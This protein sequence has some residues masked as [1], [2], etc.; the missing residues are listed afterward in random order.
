M[1]S[2]TII[3][4]HQGLNLVP[5][6]GYLWLLDKT[7]S[8]RL[9]TK[10]LSAYFTLSADL[11][12]HPQ[13]TNQCLSTYLHSVLGLPPLSSRVGFGHWPP[14]L[15]KGWAVTLQHELH[16]REH[17]CITPKRAQVVLIGMMPTRRM[18]HGVNSQPSPNPRQVLRLLTGLPAKLDRAANGLICPAVVVSILEMC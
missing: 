11:C 13:E 15:R 17:S 5:L 2:N 9:C 10:L 8:F 12:F 3:C 1:N 14:S 7:L 16:P 18:L 6:E 4:V